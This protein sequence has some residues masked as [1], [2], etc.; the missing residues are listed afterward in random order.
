MSLKHTLAL[1]SSDQIS[2]LWILILKYSP[3]NTK[4]CFDFQKQILILIQLCTSVKIYS[5]LTHINM[6][7]GKVATT[8]RRDMRTNSQP[9]HPSL[10]ECLS[11]DSEKHFTDLYSC[12]ERH[13]ALHNFHG[14]FHLFTQLNSNMIQWEIPPFNPGVTKQ[15]FMQ[16]DVV[17]PHLSF[18]NY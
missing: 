5:T 10:L 14:T 4:I 9:Q 7:I 3:S 13:S 8:K 15:L 11:V 18:V 1:N 2:E 17:H 16:R 12:T 6:E